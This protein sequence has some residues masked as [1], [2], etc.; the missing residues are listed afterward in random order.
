MRK[1]ELGTRAWGRGRILRARART[2]G[3]LRV[4]EMSQASCRNRD[5]SVLSRNAE[6]IVREGQIKGSGPSRGGIVIFLCAYCVPWRGLDI[7]GTQAVIPAERGI[8]QR[9]GEE[10]RLSSLAWER[11]RGRQLVI[12][13]FGDSEAEKGERAPTTV[14]TEEGSGWA[15]SESWTP[16]AVHASAGGRE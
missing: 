8:S 15:R 13:H 4:I 6:G 14:A 11:L 2:H 16:P 5:R 3:P 12:S 7:A 10:L 9:L 1:P